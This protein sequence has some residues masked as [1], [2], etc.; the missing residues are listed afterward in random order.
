LS[1]NISHRHWFDCEVNDTAL[2]KYQETVAFIALTLLRF[3][4]TEQ[5]HLLETMLADQLK[6][7]VF[8]ILNSDVLS[9]RRHGKFAP[10]AKATEESVT[11]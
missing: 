8:G 1:F 4:D 2:M 7:Q 6:L 11:N 10:K 5:Y 3:V 9:G